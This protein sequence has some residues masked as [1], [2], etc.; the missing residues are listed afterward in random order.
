[1]PI[2]A[3]LSSAGGGGCAVRRRRFVRARDPHAHAVFATAS[4]DAEP[5]QRQ[6]KPFFQRRNEGTQIRLSPPEIE[7][8]V[9]DPLPRPVICELAA[10]TRSVHWQ[11]VRHEIVGP[12]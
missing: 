11:I 2:A 3:I 7:H 4:D 12:R 8:D 1:M 9:G 5:R 6:D 10:A